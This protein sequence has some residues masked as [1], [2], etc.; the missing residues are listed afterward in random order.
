MIILGVL[1]EIK[2]IIKTLFTLLFLAFFNVVS[3][4]A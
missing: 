4:K 1:S 2:Y 3:R